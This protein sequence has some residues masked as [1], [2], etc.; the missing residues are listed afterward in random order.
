[1]KLLTKELE[2]RFAQVGSQEDKGDDAIVVAKFFT[3]WTNWT[4]YCLEWS[5][6]DRT[7]FGLVDGF[8]TEFGSFALEELEEINGPAG[9]RIER[10]LYW[11]ERTI[12]EV[13]AALASGARL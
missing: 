8:E 3:P 13:R 6:E 10:D 1:M 12:G 5:P 7:F 4:W 2:R 11:K 9:L